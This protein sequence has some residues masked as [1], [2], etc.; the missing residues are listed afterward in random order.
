[1]IMIIKIIRTMIT[2]IMMT[3]RL[4]QLLLTGTIKIKIKNN[5]KGIN[6]DSNDDEDMIFMV[7]M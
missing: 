2:F 6:D 4:I 1:M 3:V 5:E 7:I